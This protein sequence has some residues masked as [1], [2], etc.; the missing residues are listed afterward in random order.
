MFEKNRCGNELS[1]LSFTFCRFD[2]VTKKIVSAKFPGLPKTD[3]KVKFMVAKFCEQHELPQCIGAIERTHSG[4][5]SI[6]Y[7]INRGN[8]YC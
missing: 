3:E 7:F 6:S 1:L 2:T 8:L 4:I 5:K